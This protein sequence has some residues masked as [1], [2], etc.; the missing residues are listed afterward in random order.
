MTTTI[1]RAERVVIPT[2]LRD[3]VGLSHGTEVRIQLRG[4]YPEIEPVATITVEKR[5]LLFVG[6]APA[7]TTLIEPVAGDDF[8]LP[9]RVNNLETQVR[10]I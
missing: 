10:L 4:G 3:Q 8:L 5:G 9:E 2:A 7:G 1:D 6:V